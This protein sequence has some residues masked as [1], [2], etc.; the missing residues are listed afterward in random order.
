M[1]RIVD[2]LSGMLARQITD[3]GVVV[4]Y[5]PEGHYRQVAEQ[6]TA[7]PSALLPGAPGTTV[8]CDGGSLFALRHR[9]DAIIN[10]TEPPHLLVY[11]PRARIA[12]G[13]AL[14]E[15]ESMG[16]IMQPGAQSR[17]RNTRLSLVVREAL[18]PVLGESGLADIEKQIEHGR[19]SLADC[20][21]L[22]DQGGS[23]GAGVISLVF[24]T[25]NPAEVALAFLTSEQHDAT[26]VEKSGVAEVVRLLNEGLDAKMPS[27]LQ[28]GEIRT[29]VGRHVIVSEIAH[30]LGALPA[31]L[32]SLPTAVTPAGRMACAQVAE[33]WRGTTTA[34]EGYALAAQALDTELGLTAASWTAGQAAKVSG[35]RSA[36]IATIEQVERS[37]MTDTA[38]AALATV[39][40]LREGFWAQQDPLLD[41]RLALAYAAGQVLVRL[42][43]QETALQ[44]QTL[45]VREFVT[46]YTGGATPWCMIDT[47]QR[48]ME[49]IWHDFDFDHA[50]QHQ[51]LDSLITHARHRFATAGSQAAERFAKSW[52]SQSFQIPHLPK[53]IGIFDDWVRP[54][55]GDDKVAYLWID[56]LRFEMAR[57]L[58][59]ESLGQD[60]S[61]DLA[62]ATA[63]PPTITEIGMAALLPG[64]AASPTVVKVKEGKLGLAINGT[65]IAKREDRL[66]WL[67]DHA[68]V[69]VADIRLENLLPKPK[70]KDLEQIKKAQLVLVTSQEIDELCEQGNV[71]LARKAMDGVLELLARACRLLAS[72]GVTK[73]YLT[74][75]H[76]YLFAEE[77]GDEAKIE[78]PGG[79]TV[80]LHRR[81]WVGQG[82]N[83][84][85]A[86]LRAP[87]AAFGLG[88][89]LEIAAPMGFGAFKA[90]GG[91]LAYFHGGL[92]PQEVLI[93]LLELTPKR[94]FGQ[95]ASQAIAWSLTSASKKITTR[96]ARIQIT[97]ACAFPVEAPA[98][99]IEVLNGTEIIGEA[100]V[101]DDDKAKSGQLIQLQA[102]PEAGIE[103]KTVTLR[104][105]K[106]AGATTT[107]RLLDETGRLLASVDIPT[108]ISM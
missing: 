6:L 45:D 50:G 1:G 79:K 93:P 18:K 63:T 76:G 94:A 98:V 41:Q 107:V 13:D 52:S 86:I 106:K 69:T 28:P 11:V 99:Q 70:K 33:R 89:D 2:H 80:D 44:D 27:D 100:I 37:L 40:R 83:A 25:A 20:E 55:L 3:A 16:V 84:D 21:R 77:V 5:D 75:D 31:A 104:I 82:G 96:V 105:T 97:G 91:G 54:G 42:A 59:N 36:S 66:Q 58:V 38:A 12:A 67:T 23:L 101:G 102:A 65:V 34:E 61:A 85:P 46:R 81:V 62:V 92:S 56:A 39:V 49:Q 87:L 48:L 26:L 29:R 24:G 71:L 15:L 60:F 19:L 4:W 90:K 88:G 74:S 51:T 14:V 32:A 47:H 8:A 22:A 64:S 53:Q 72:H 68:G 17:P 30:V 95:S 103:P 43:E 57:Q 9:V 35:I 7:N 78:A 73:I 10:G 108:A